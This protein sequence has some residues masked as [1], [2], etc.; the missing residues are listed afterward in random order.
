MEIERTILEG[1]LVFTPKVH[2]DERGFFFESWNLTNFNKLIKSNLNFVQDNHS[3]S[4]YNVLRGLH[5]Q[6]K[7]PQ[8]KLVRVVSGEILDVIVDINVKSKTFGKWI[9]VI[10]SSENKKQIWIPPGYAHGIL[11]KSK[12]A[13]LLYKV[14]DYYDP[15]FERCI[16]W[17]DPTLNIDWTLKN[18]PI[19]SKKDSQGALLYDAEK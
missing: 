17:N 1:V 9:S 10:I 14:T 12:Y 5:Y 8:G 16:I 6:I 4:N 11:V 19:I 15:E 18:S 7:K 2:K 13:D 3:H